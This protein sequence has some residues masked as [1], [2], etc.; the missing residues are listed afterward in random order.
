MSKNEYETLF[1]SPNEI[2]K[3]KLL[4]ENEFTVQ[5]EIQILHVDQTYKWP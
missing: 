3:K 4:E 5:V 2:N 1:E